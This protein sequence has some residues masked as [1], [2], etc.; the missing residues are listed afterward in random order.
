ALCHHERAIAQVVLRRARG[1]HAQ[2]RLRTDGGQLL[3]GNGGRRRADTSGRDGDLLAEQ[4][5]RVR[6]ILTVRGHLPG[7]VEVRGDQRAASG[8]PR[9]Q[10]VAA[11]LAALERNMVLPGHPAPCCSPSCQPANAQSDGEELAYFL[12]R[13]TL[14]RIIWYRRVATPYAYHATSG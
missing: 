12:Q 6:H 4:R 8:I 3:H 7:V 1:A 5:A 11:D 2:Q 10:D 14:R 13:A 9:Q